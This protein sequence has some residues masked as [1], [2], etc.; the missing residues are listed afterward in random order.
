[1]HE[2]HD[3]LY[4]E[5]LQDDGSPFVSDPT[6]HTKRWGQKKKEEKKRGGGPDGP[7]ALSSSPYRLDNL[8]VSDMDGPPLSHGGVGGPQFRSAVVASSLYTRLF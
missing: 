4:V 7:T 8:R 3:L 2:S 1:M 6:G 5:P